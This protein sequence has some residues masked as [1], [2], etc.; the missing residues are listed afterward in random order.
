[1]VSHL[2]YPDPRLV[3]LQVTGRSNIVSAA[4]VIPFLSTAAV[5]SVISGVVFVSKLHLVRPPY[6]GLLVLLPIGMVRSVSEFD[7]QTLT[8][9]DEGSYLDHR[10]EQFLRQ[11]DRIHDHRRSRLRR[12]R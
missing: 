12:R 4:L 2:S 7:D 9:C 5:F 8:V 10:P 6:L 1:M 11:A 3:F